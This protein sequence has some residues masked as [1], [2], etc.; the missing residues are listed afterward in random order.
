MIDIKRQY[1]KIKRDKNQLLREIGNNGVTM[2]KGNNFEAQGFIDNNLSRWKKK[3]KPD[4]R[5]V[6]VGKTTMLRNTINY[7]AK[8]NRVE[9]GTL[10]PYGRRHNEGLKGMPKR[11]FMGESAALNKIN[12]RTIG[13]FLKKR[14]R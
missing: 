4:G 1:N 12:G 10:V 5:K 9:F 14:M 11:Q 3:K 6:L 13:M 2:F 7:K 8:T